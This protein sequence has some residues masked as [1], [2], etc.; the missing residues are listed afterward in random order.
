ML[1]TIDKA[2]I[3][4]LGFGYMRLP[5]KGNAFDTE[6]ID[7]MA[8]IFLESGGTYIDTAFIYD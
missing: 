3:S 4:K 2:K 8:D 7:K 1:N 6:Q 5:T